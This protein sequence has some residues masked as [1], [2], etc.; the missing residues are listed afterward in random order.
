MRNKIKKIISKL[1]R[2]GSGKP[3]VFF[4]VD[5]DFHD[6]YALAH[7]RTNMS[8]SDN[9][10]RRQRHY[11]LMQLLKQILPIVNK[12][13]VA[14]CGCWQGL[15][16]YQI[17]YQLKYNN[18]RNRFFIFDSFAG[19]SEF[20][21]EDLKGNVVKDH[22][23]RRKEFSASLKDVQANLCE[24]D[25]I[26][27]K[28]GWIPERFDEVSGLD[29]SFVHIDV[30]LYQPI[31]DSLEFFYPRMIKGGVVVFDDYGYL[32]FPGAKT[33]VDEFMQG[34][35]DFFLHLAAGSAFIIK[36]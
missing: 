10:L 29:F 31:K 34:K 17:A 18:F 14:E 23:K 24:F 5:K 6:V 22:N 2:K 30:D 36:D 9:T 21:D 11:A 19:L 27:F 33:A 4:E 8:S 28:K 26:E 1:T 16:A 7:K 32:S 15:S 20:N 13:H 3:V 12:G 25:F 35:N